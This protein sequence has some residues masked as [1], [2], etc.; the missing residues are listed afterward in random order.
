MVGNRSYADHV[1]LHEEGDLFC[2]AIEWDLNTPG[3]CTFFFYSSCFIHKYIFIQNHSF[4]PNV[5]ILHLVDVVISLVDNIR[6]A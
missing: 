3:E 2:A 1:F 5:L 6:I 4:W